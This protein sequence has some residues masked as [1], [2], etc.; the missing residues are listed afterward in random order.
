MSYFGK[1]NVE[2][3]TMSSIWIEVAL[4]GPWGRERQ[5]GIPMTVEEVISDGLSVVDAG[6][7]IIHV[8]AYDSSTGRQ[9]DE[10]ETYARIIE[11]IRSKADAIVYPTIP[12]TGSDFAAA[13]AERR[14]A[15]TAELARRGLIEWTVLDPGSVSFVRFDEIETSSASFIYQNPLADIREGLRIA[16]EH[17]LHPGYAIYEPGFT[18]LGA[19]L[20]QAAPQL[21]TPIYRFMFSDEFAWGFPPNAVHLDAHLQLLSSV[22]PTACWMIAGLGVDI[23]PLIGAAVAR[24]GHVRVGLED[25]P[26]GTPLTNREWVQQA[27][28]LIRD[29]GGEPASAAEVRAS[30]Q[31]IDSARV[32]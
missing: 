7:A 19:A 30:L 2:I 5:P 3:T 10:W 21:P 24:G 27:A 32:A 1:Q 18:R 13:N 16:R 15:H 29:A 22:A 12:L 25:A 28:R 26:W 17:R 23:R 4:N 11:G 6:A 14:F 31:A 20:A 8:H 9:R